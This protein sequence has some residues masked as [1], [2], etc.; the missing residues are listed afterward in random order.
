MTSR[1]ADVIV[2]GAGVFGLHAALAILRKGRSV[3]VLEQAGAVGAG[4]SG[5][6]VGALAPH[7][8][9]RWTPKKQFQLISEINYAI[10]EAFRKNNIR[11][12]FPQRDLHVQMTP[13]MEILAGGKKT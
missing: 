8:P 7:M 10:D 6:I 2:I 1:H 13:A 12:P 9:E 5:G 4:A 3:Q 11:I